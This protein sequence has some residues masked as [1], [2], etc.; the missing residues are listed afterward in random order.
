M[1]KSNQ[2]NPINKSADLNFNTPQRSERLTMI[3]KALYQL[4]DVVLGI[5]FLIGS[6]LFFSDSTV[7][8]GT[9]L[10]VIGSVQMTVRPLIALSHDLHLA[11]KYKKSEMHDE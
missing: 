11:H 3:Y 10:F 1:S 6:F 9:I 2:Q 4:N 5:I 7:T 8:L